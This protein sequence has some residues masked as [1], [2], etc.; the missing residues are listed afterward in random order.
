MAKRPDIPYSEIANSALSAAESLLE[1]WLPDG[2]IQSG[3]FKARNPLRADN[4]VG[5]FSVNI[6]SGKWGDFA[7]NDAG[8]DL[9]S[10][11]AYLEGIEQW[12]AAIDIADQIGFKLP[13]GCRPDAK[14]EAVRKKPI[15]DPETIKTSKPKEE[16]PWHPLYPIPFPTNVPEPPKAHVKR[17]LPQMTWCYKNASGE[18]LGYIYRFTT[19][20][21]GK[22]TIPLTFCKNEKTGKHDWRWMQWPEP[23]PLYGLDRLAANPDAW[24]L[25]VEGEKCADAAA[26]L[27]GKAV[28]V[29]WPGGCKAVDK[30]DWSPLVGRNIIAWADCDAQRKKLTKAE[31]TAGID[32]AT[33]PLLPEFEQPGVKAMLH[34]ADKLKSLNVNQSFKMV[35]IPKPGEKPDGWDIADAIAEGLTYSQLLDYVTKCRPLEN[36]CETKSTS[37]PQTAVAEIEEPAWKRYLLRQGRGGEIVPCMANVYDILKNDER[38]NGVFAFNEHSMRPTKLKKPPY[39]DKSG[40]VGDFTDIDAS[41]CAMWLTRLYRFNPSP[42]LT[43]K[44][45]EALSHAQAFHPVKT[46][47]NGL[48]WDG[49]RRVDTWLLDYMNVP[50]T[51]Y[52]KRI[53]RWFLMGMVKR[54]LEPG[55]KFDYCLVFEGKQGR[56]KS[57]AFRVLAGEWFG[58]TDLDLQNK[59]SMSALRGKWLY[60]FAELGS[61]ARAESTRQKSFLSRQVDEFRPVFGTREIRCPRQLVFGGTT[62]EWEWNKDATGGRRFWPIPVDSDVDIEGLEQARDQLFAEAMV[63]VSEGLRY[64]PTSKEQSEIFDHEQLKRSTPETFVDALHDHVNS[65]TTEFSLHYAATDWLKLDAAKL[66][67]DVQTRIGAALRILGCTKIEKRTNA[68][69]RFWY[70][71]PERNGAASMADNAENGG[72]EDEIPF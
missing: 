72:F 24:V 25:L 3:E 66:T 53:A 52:S 57:A 60:E 33:L 16:S 48:K 13:D 21:G 37:T 45:I 31:L 43:N 67:R 7:T 69:T 26:G 51:P 39:W 17:G 6:R 30:V 23:R 8:N 56:K 46:Y 70:K 49:A 28:L 47:L 18:V 38:W 5:S 22:E 40:E 20:D 19:S 71:P 2:N 55:C 62:N 61:L 32:A 54:V 41:M 35:D 42:E 11:Y 12:E 15:V 68:L 14:P 1:R 4:K 64:W 50:V 58:D 10:L 34:I 29:T 63:M 44:T 27:D 36:F 65:Y 59:D 9:I